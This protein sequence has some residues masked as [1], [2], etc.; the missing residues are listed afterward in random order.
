MLDSSSSVHVE[1]SCSRRGAGQEANKRLNTYGIPFT[2]LIF[3]LPRLSAP[4]RR[5]LLRLLRD[6]E[7]LFARAFDESPA[8]SLPKSGIGRRAQR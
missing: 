6:F 5:M 7:T 2:I 4:L 8:A 3:G 1:A